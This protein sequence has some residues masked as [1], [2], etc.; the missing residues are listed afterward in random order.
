MISNSHFKSIVPR[1]EAIHLMADS[2]HCLISIG[3]MNTNQLPSK[4]IE[5]LS[6]GK[7]VIHF[8]EVAND[9]VNLI[10][11]N[12]DNLFILTKE[13]NIEEFFLNLKKYFKN[14]DSFNKELFIEN[15]T[16]SSVIKI[17]DLT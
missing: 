17:L 8:A 6:T 14:I 1:E 2:V 4:V 7:P 13:E 16:A 9:P 11:E 10:A 15:Y 5:Y 12:F 3:N